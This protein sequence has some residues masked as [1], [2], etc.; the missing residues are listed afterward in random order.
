MGINSAWDKY[1]PKL[2]GTSDLDIV[3]SYATARFMIIKDRRLGFLN[4]I[5]KV[6]IVIYVVLQLWME[7]SYLFDQTIRGSGRFTLSQPTSNC[8]HA[9]REDPTVSPYC[10]PCHTPDPPAG[11][12]CY[13]AFPNV[14]SLAYCRQSELP[15]KKV[16]KMCRFEES[17]A[18]AMVFQSSL[19]VSTKGVEL[20]QTK[21]CSANPQDPLYKDGVCD[22]VYN[23]T[24]RDTFYYAD[25]RNFSVN[26]YHSLEFPERVTNRDID[27]ALYVGVDPWKKKNSDAVCARNPDAMSSFPNGYLTDISPCYIP[28]VKAADG[29]DQYVLNEILAA[30]QVSLDHDT[31]GPNKT[32]R[33]VGTTIIFGVE[34]LN[35]KKWEVMTRHTRPRYVYHITPLYNNTFESTEAIYD[36]YP[37]TRTLLLRSGVRIVAVQSGSLRSFA[38]SQLLITLATSLTLLAITTTIVDI[39]S[40]NLMS[41]S[42]L[43]KDYKFQETPDMSDVRS[44]SCCATCG[45]ETYRIR[46]TLDAPGYCGICEGE[47]VTGT[48]MYRCVRCAHE[49]CSNCL[50]GSTIN[51]P[52]SIN[53]VALALELYDQNHKGY[54]SYDEYVQMQLECG[55]DTEGSSAVYSCEVMD[56][57][58]YEA[59]C[60]PDYIRHASP[61]VK[62]HWRSRLMRKRHSI[63]E[64]GVFKN[65]MDENTSLLEIGL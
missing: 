4:L 22:K 40:T 38:F 23:T 44:G 6:G 55:M 32:V 47:F 63:V 19:L 15:Y 31:I 25:I 61:D 17:A 53:I 8:T 48:V 16:K 46:T 27:G 29:S 64:S 20:Q 39:I 18:T 65:P 59:S 26:I 13:D 45:N 35:W 5:C 12:E 37:K 57:A 34:Y 10:I 7:G 3:F 54:L 49:R 58:K 1:A 56:R 36:E 60:F 24:S 50:C 51:K 9:Q 42:Q 14:T 41:N 43:Y 62:K 21:T 52:A 11:T 30:G 33:S 2:F 28:P